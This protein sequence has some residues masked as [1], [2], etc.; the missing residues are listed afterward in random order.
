VDPSKIALVGVGSG[1]NASLIAASSDPAIP[2]V[3][4]ASPVDG[5]D[6]AFSNRVGSD[7]LWLAPLRPLFKWT[8]QVM[9][10]VDASQLDMGNYTSM[11]QT[12]HV[13]VTDASQGLMLPT[14]IRGIKS[15]LQRHCSEQVATA[16]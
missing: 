3:V 2:A 12:R 9:Y 10:G 16:R 15:F 4:L 5:F 14:S 8:F 11:M 1:A 6:R 7:H 13:L